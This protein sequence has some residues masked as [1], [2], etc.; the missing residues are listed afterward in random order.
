M[1]IYIQ[2]DVSAKLLTIE[3]SKALINPAVSDC[4]GNR[5][6]TPLLK[7]SENNGIFTTVL[8]AAELEC[9]SP[10]HPV[11]YNFTATGIIERFGFC[12]LET[13]DNRAVLL[14]GKPVFLRGYI[15]GIV[16]HEHPNMTGESL[17]AAAV[18][19]IRQAK[20]YGFNLVRF[21]SRIPTPE[22]IE[23]AD[24]EG[25]LIHMEIGF[26]Y[27]Y[28]SQGNKKK[29]SM[30]NARWEETI[31][32][33]RNRPSAAIFCIGNEMHKSGH[34][35]EVHNLYNR[36]KALAPGKLIMDNSGWGE[37]DRSSADI[38]SQHIAYYYPFKH[39]DD[40]FDTD[41]CWRMN[42]STY[43]E[44]L[45]SDG[46]TGDLDFTVR[47]EAVP[48]RPVLAHEAI[49]YIDIP[50]YAA[51]NKKFD[52]FCAR[53]GKEYLEANG[54][55]KPRY[56]TE[57]PALIERKNLTA[58]MP[59]Y[60]KGSQI[61]KK[62][63]I[64]TYLERLRLSGLCGFEML[65]FADCLKYENKNGIVDFFDDDKY[66]DARWMNTFNADA[67]L[68]ARF[69]N[70]VFYCGTPVKMELFVSNFLEQPE[71]KGSLE[72]SVNGREFWKG[73]NFVLA[74]NLQKLTGMSLNFKS[75]AVPEKVI[76]SALFRSEKLVLENSW[77]IWL[78][79][80]VKVTSGPAVSLSDADMAKFLAPAPAAADSSI[81]VTDRFD[82]TVLEK[83]EANKHVFL[84]YHRDKP[85]NTYYLPGALE[86][87]KPCI[88]DR[89]SNLGGFVNS[90]VLE[91]A[92]ACD[93]YFEANMQP[94]LEGAYKVNL[95][96]F[97][98]PV[99]E[100]ICGID[101]PVR[102][103]MKGLIH[104]IKDFIPD[105]TLRNFSHCFSL[106]ITGGGTL[107]VCTLGG[108]KW[109]SAPVTENFFAALLN[110]PEAF[111]TDK[112]IP[113][114]D[115]K[116]YLETVT[117][118]GECKEDVMNHFWEIDNK[119]VEDTLFWEATGI[120]LSKRK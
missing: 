96:H 32:R 24:E 11:L 46:S 95:D 3:S 71:I 17:K 115:F 73:D 45:E 89:G 10:N 16:A 62:M 109:N 63:G 47:R 118:A 88:W 78:Y 55:E 19:N 104:N 30:D 112:A 18:K 9:W 113:L 97:P 49:H 23:A 39:H 116:A 28:D 13:L 119:P 15:R 59:D 2:S 22:F 81:F 65:Q 61:F 58:K 76:V 98:V 93:R 57:L 114:A 91:K 66:I 25:M 42:G 79:P 83:L 12:E 68:L 51:L 86:R 92:L 31:L 102:D 53:V 120:D 29:L 36:G 5:I 108:V 99:E 35:P 6:N 38:F 20:K 100:H 84:L 26:A 105:D 50:D 8:D 21:H 1:S 110:T 34:Q 111:E 90:P 72:V 44:V 75:R 56:L 74:G 87:F 7:E 27:E 33:Y 103:R 77:Q 60:I 40:M 70:E 64:K 67:A 4:S 107:T 48:L 80:Q 41:A 54:I 101:K 94:L 43:D 14:N 52:D 106:K 85:G 69:E 117:A 82:D 37:F